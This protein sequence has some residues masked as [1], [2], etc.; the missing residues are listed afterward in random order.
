MKILSNM[1]NQEKISTNSPLDELLDGGIEKRT[2]TQ[3]YGPPGVGKTNVCLNIAINVAKKG[4]KVV[5]IDPEGGISVDTIRQG[6][7][8]VRI[9]IP[10]LKT[11]LY[12][13][14]PH[15][16]NRKR[17]SDLLNHGYLPIVRML[18]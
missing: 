15:S 11:S 7:Y 1:T 12:L 6:K 13:N 2:I 14:Q 8:L 16:R 10:L 18:S 9:L 4:K 3:V 5:Y 17:I